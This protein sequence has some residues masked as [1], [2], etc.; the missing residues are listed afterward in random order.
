M[1]TPTFDSNPVLLCRP[2]N[3]HP[4]IRWIPFSQNDYTLHNY[5]TNIPP[6]TCWASEQHQEHI[7][8]TRAQCMASYTLVFVSVETFFNCCCFE[9][10]STVHQSVMANLIS[11]VISSLVPKPLCC[12]QKIK[13]WWNAHD[14]GNI[15]LRP[16]R[17]VSVKFIRGR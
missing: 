2:L 8:H 4:Q 16:F 12:M 1:D 9:L 13:V 6:Y 15:S 3:D 14:S 5:D 11:P 7:A 17:I 10:I